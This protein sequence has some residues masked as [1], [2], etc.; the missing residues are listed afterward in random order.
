V[1]DAYPMIESCTRYQQRW[2]A[3]LHEHSEP[4]Y[5]EGMLMLDNGERSVPIMGI[6][7]YTDELLDDLKRKMDA[8]EPPVVDLDTA[9]TGVTIERA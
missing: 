8:G 4:N 6:K 2:V 7:Y 3:Y 9:P 5:I 1:A